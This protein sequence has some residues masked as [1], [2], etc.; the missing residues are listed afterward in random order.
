MGVGYIDALDIFSK[1]IYFF[2]E[3]SLYVVTG[4]KK[5]TMLA[6]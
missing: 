1:S 6:Y 5:Y 4:F 2:K 3:D